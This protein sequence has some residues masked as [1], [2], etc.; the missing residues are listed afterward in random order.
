MPSTEA[1]PTSE[2]DVN[3]ARRRAIEAA[4][5]ACADLN[6]TPYYLNL[7]AYLSLYLELE[8]ECRKTKTYKAQASLWLPC[9]C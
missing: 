3:L 4:C 7:V 2:V 5:F 8:I 6:V 1:T 9:C